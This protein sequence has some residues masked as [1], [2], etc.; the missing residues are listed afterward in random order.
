MSPYRYVEAHLYYAQFLKAQNNAEHIH[1][2]KQVAKA[3]MAV[4]KKYYLNFLH[5]QFDRL[6]SKIS[7]QDNSDY[8]PA[9]YPAPCGI[10]LQRYVQEY[11]KLHGI[12]P[13]K[14][15]KPAKLGS[16]SNK[17][18]NKKKKRPKR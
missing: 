13:G 1:K 3:G 7:A 12:K 6:L 15:V 9:D 4:V 18:S 5:F 11:A 8:N 10:D 16:T 2:Y 17:T 14:A